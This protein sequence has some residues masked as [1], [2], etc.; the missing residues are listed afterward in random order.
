VKRMNESVGSESKTRQISNSEFLIG[1]VILIGAVE[2]ARRGCD[3]FSVKDGG[4]EEEVLASLCADPHLIKFM[5][6]YRWKEFC[7]FYPS[8]RRPS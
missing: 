3:S 1:F 5:S 2:F 8:V 4:Q 6:F 7:H